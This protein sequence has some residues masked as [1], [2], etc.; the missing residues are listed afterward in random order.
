MYLEKKTA[1]CVKHNVKD[2]HLH[3]T[4]Y[5]NTLR[6]FKSYVCKQKLISSTSHTV[7][8]AHTRKVVLTAFDTKRWLREDT[9]HAHPHGLKDTVPDPDLS[10]SGVLQMLASLV[11]MP[12]RLESDYGPDSGSE[13]DSQSPCWDCSLDS[14]SQDRHCDPSIDFFYSQG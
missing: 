7:R 8:T 1:K 4:H 5:L 14:F 2:D 11:V 3:F 13:S 9:I 6:S 12:E 10:L